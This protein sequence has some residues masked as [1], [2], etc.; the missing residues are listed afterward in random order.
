MNQQ[1]RPSP[2]DNDISLDQVSIVL[3][4]PQG[5]LN[6]GSVCRVMANFGISDLRLVEPE[7]DHLSDPARKMAVKAG[8]LLEQARLFP[9]LQDAL[10]DCQLAIGTTRRFGKYRENL[11]HPDQAATL[12]LPLTTNGRVALVFGREDSGL[13]T[14]EL[15]LCQTLMTIPTEDAIGSMNLAQAVTVV[16]YEF[17]K[18]QG[19]L[20]GKA[21]GRKRLASNQA[22]ES[23]FQHMRQSLLNIDYLDPQNP[24]HILRTFRRIFGRAGLNDRDVKVLQ[25]LW[26]RIDWVTQELAK[27]EQQLIQ[28]DGP[29]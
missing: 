16:L 28:D 18:A 20:Q 12:A 26:R 22:Q 13:L 11:I 17:Y 23:M 4:S 25:G 7:A 14:E 9:S 8:F 24:D 2:T 10:A 3:V 6:V 29:V 1:N 19:E 27:H 15:D 21:W 5:P